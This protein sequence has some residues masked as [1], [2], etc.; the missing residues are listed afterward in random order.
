MQ[1]SAEQQ[2]AYELY[3][4]GENMFLTG[5]G[6]TGKSALIRYIQS[7]AARQSL[8]IHVCAMT[9]CAAVMLECNAKT[10]HSWAGIGLGNDTVENLVKRVS[11]NRFARALWKGTD[12]LIVDEVSMMSQRMFELLDE[13]GRKIRVKQSH[14]PFGGIQLI[15]TGDFYQLPP[16]S[17]DKGPEQTEEEKR[18]ANFCFQSPL[19]LETFPWKNHIEL[20]HIFRQTDST[21]QKILN[22]V[23]KGSLKQSSFQILS[24]QVDKPLPI[25]G[26]TQFKPTKLYP[27]RNQVKRVN[28]DEMEILTTEERVFELRRKYDVEM[29]K[30]E[31]LINMNVTKEQ[32]ER[33]LNYLQ[34]N[35][36]CE[37]QVRL[38]VGTQVMCVVNIRLNNGD[39]ICNGSQGIVV[40]FDDSGGG[41]EEGGLPVVRYYRNNYEMKME[42]H[43][44]VSEN[45]PGIGIEQIPLI[46]A[47]ALTIHKSQGSTLDMAEIDAG[48]G[49]FECGQTYVALSRVKTLDGLFLSA[50]DPRR[51]RI[52]SEVKRFYE[53][54]TKEKEAI[55][56]KSEEPDQETNQETKTKEPKKTRQVTFDE[57]R[58]VP[59]AIAV[60]I[61]QNE[62]G[63]TANLPTVAA[64]II[65]STDAHENNEHQSC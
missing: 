64:T 59:E 9:G 57:Y 10:V 31:R 50:F 61:P 47:W 44:W 41:S 20:T 8:D 32:M 36:L 46:H 29:T 54:M 51:I 11:K 24:Q 39:M 2:T 26:D 55:Q 30:A 5:P 22:Q 25:I 15:F 3:L 35:V 42:R 23:R 38:K 6:G 4:R 7:H 53:L 65:S 40:R 34:G 19:W 58:Y 49:I 17:K 37:A 16:V 33:E 1:L 45:I 18:A 14:R 28:E 43:I 52:H 56:Q 12:V 21:W 62:I 60:P 13:I 63:A 27:T 48:T